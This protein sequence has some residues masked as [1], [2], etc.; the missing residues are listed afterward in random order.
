MHK[1]TKS[2]NLSS[3]A[4]DIEKKLKAANK[5]STDLQRFLNFIPSMLGYWDK[6]L[7]NQHSN[8]AYA[9]YFGKTP[10]QIKD[11]HIKDLLGPNLYKKNLPYVRAALKG[12]SQTFE[13]AIPT[14]S[15]EVKYTLANY[16]PDI[17]NGKVQGFFVIVTDIASVKELE[18]KNREIEAKLV[19]NSKMSS[20][21]E[22]ASGIAHE[23][24]NPLTIIYGNSCRLESSLKN[25]NFDLLKAKELIKEISEM[26][27]RIEKIVD[28]LRMISRNNQ[29]TH[30]EK[31]SVSNIIKQTLT[32]CETRFKS[33]DIKLKQK[34]TDL[35]LKIKCQPVSVSQIILNILNN[36]YDAVS[37][38]AIRWIQIEVIDSND[39]IRIAISNSGPKISPK[40]NEKIF[41][42]FFTTKPVGQGT[43]LG[44]SISKGLAE[45]NGGSLY[46]NQYSKRTQF[47]LTL[48]K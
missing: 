27:L 5:K 6:N 19:A 18:A 24:N 45:S 25:N 1:K 32:L 2:L 33:E 10:N 16:V 14:P 28:S 40:L 30:I 9:S 15:G 23:I 35:D 42:P 37:K 3:T 38:C 7:I 29:K 17:V 13:R 47:V 22:M 11:L 21:G 39:F 36:A 46:L 4:K 31:E 41:Q 20:L 8:Q 26:S 34:N 12:I 44:L 48:P 43:G